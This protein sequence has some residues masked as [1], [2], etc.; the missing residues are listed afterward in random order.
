M[1]LWESDGD[2]PFSV[3]VN[4]RGQLSL[5]PA[6]RPFPHGWHSTGFSGTHT[7]CLAEIERVPASGTWLPASSGGSDAPGPRHPGEG[8]AAL[9][10]SVRDLPDLSV[11]ELIRSRN[12]PGAAGRRSGRGPGAPGRTPGHQRRVGPGAGGRGL[13]P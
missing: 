3:V 10:G 2:L 1:A 11:T 6:E 8:E 9:R 7:E 13:R 5:W 12:L 4:S